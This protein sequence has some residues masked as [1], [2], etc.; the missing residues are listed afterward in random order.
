MKTI[1]MI[2]GMSWESSVE[3]Y[4]L[5][6]EL[7]REKSNRTHTAKCV[8]VS[9]DFYE[10]ETLQH[11]SRWDEAAVIL[12]D[13]ARR[14]EIAGADFLIL[15]CNTMHM[16]EDAITSVVKIPFLH[17]TDATA[18]EIQKQ[19][20]QTTGLLGTRFTMESDYFIKRLKERFDINAITPEKQ[21]RDFV[22][23][24][25]Y[26]EICRG[27]IKPESKERYRLIMDTLVDQGAE[28]IIFGCTEIP[29][30][31]RPED[32]PI[33]VF[34]TLFLHAQAAVDYALSIPPH[35]A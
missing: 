10:I 8:M 12:S 33:P 24:V 3:Y 27:I 25:I 1:G 21:D 17:I 34:D 4:R 7:T 28:G 18:R 23:D 32:C 35:P 19:G 2:A 31:I 14:I 22:H 26:N 11:E 20:I 30:L 15:C 13:A 5:L 6:N 29:L 9:V 16:L